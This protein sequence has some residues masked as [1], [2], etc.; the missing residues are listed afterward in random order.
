MI[1][2][3]EE[4]LIMAHISNSIS[5]KMLQTPKILI[6]AGCIFLL[7]GCATVYQ[8][9]YP[10]HET[11]TNTNIALLRSGMTPTE[12]QGIFGKPDVVYDAS[13]GENVGEPW[14]G[15]V[16]VY[17]TKEDPSFEH[18]KRYKK[19]MLVFY[20]PGENMKLNHWDIEE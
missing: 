9:S 5:R 13:F 10:G 14:A 11:F 8:Y 1:Q 12:V 6:I 16:W 4:S 19:N 7:L 20:P 3:T 2:M 15:R 17:F 18:V